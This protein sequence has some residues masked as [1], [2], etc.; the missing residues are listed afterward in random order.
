M[1][2][3][4]FTPALFTLDLFNGFQLFGLCRSN[5]RSN[6]RMVVIW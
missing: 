2:T 3:A 1:S 4:H 5:V 6:I